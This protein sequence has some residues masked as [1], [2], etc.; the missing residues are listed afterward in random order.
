MK[1]L[2]KLEQEKEAFV[3]EVET[4]LGSLHYVNED[5]AEM[6]WNELTEGEHGYLYD[7]WV[8]PFLKKLIRERIFDTRVMW[9]SSHNFLITK[10][11]IIEE[12]E[13]PLGEG[14]EGEH[15]PIFPL[16]DSEKVKLKEEWIRRYQ[17]NSLLSHLSNIE[18]SIATF[19]EGIEFKIEPPKVSDG[20]YNG[21][22]GV[23]E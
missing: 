11:G 6:R 3:N 7:E 18:K 2:R 22:Y 8:F 5:D 13:Q 23:H 19:K 9:N 16:K 1:D 21:L 20:G 10:E 4:I 14:D 15:A 12:L 17:Y